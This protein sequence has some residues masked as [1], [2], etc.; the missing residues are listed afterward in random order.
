[1]NR[2]VCARV[3]RA[4]A[5]SV[6]LARTAAVMF[7]LA[8]FAFAFSFSFSFSFGFAS[9][10]ALADGAGAQPATKGPYV[11]ALSETTATVRVELRAAAPLAVELVGERAGEGGDAGPRRLR[12]ESPSATMH[13]VRVT[14]LAPSTRYAYTILAAGAP[15]GTGHLVTAPEPASADAS[16]PHTFL[17]YGDDR[18]DDDAHAAIVRDMA[19]VPADF[20][21][22]T[23]DMVADGGSA[24]NWATFFD[25]ER[26]LLRERPLFS[27]IGNH[28][29]YNDA[30]GA[31]FSRYFGF[32]D[33]AGATH[34]YGTV[35][36][37]A[38]RFFF[39]NGT[40]EWGG[41]P[42]R[43]WLER[44][45]SSAD[46]E[47]GVVWRFAIVHQGPW[48]SGPHGQNPRLLAAHVPELLAAHHVDLVFSG[49]DHIYERGDAGLLKYVVSGGGGAPVY[50]NIH[51]TATTRK[52]EAAY[53]FVEVTTHGD[54]LQMV[55]HRLDGS[56][57]ERCGFAKGAPWD[58]D[59]PLATASASRE[60]VEASAGAVGE[61]NAASPDRP[62]ACICD[63]YPG[64]ERESPGTRAWAAAASL[65]LLLGCV[66]RY[67]R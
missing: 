1:M 60:P 28:E 66:R 7:A 43:E 58:C 40:G 55:V 49:H 8:S 23:G 57:L 53:H 54:G 67:A 11:T 27:A 45:L 36:V 64:A 35:R 24:A 12:F 41:G 32:D 44:A 30:A 16:A 33:A 21:V 15:A 37:G 25:I 31:N 26:D 10:S 20:L 3:P 34:P 18:T 39:M 2:D 19:H 59:S 14:G 48:S 5:R 62:S 42:E 38:L 63:A 17:V 13:V 50:R 51:P 4:C 29:L 65:V 46:A 56:L 22:N 61:S 6:G 52:V 9:A 47:A